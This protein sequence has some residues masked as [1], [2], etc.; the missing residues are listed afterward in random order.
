MTAS[1]QGGSQEMIEEVRGL[2]SQ[3]LQDIRKLF[4]N[5][6]YFACKGILGYD[7]LREGAH[8]PLCD[9]LTYDQ[10]VRK[11]VLMPRGH[12]KSTI[13][14]IGRPIQLAARNP[15]LYRGCIQNE[16]ATKANLFIWEIKQHWEK[17]QVLRELYPELVPEK[18]SGPGSDWSADM[19]SIRRTAVMKESTWTAIGAGGS[20]VGLHFNHIVPDDLIGEQHKASRADMERVKVWN[21]GQ[22]ALLDNA[23]TDE[24]CWIGTRKAVDDVYADT[25][26]VFEGELALFIREPI[27]DG[28]PIFPLK[29]SME[30]FQRM[31][32]KTPEEWA[33]DYMNNPIG[34]GGRDWAGLAI[35]EWRLADDGMTYIYRDPDTDERKTC[36]RSMLDIVITVDPNSGKPH[37]PDQAAVVVHGTTPDDENLILETKLGRPSP[38][39][40]V[41]WTFDSAVHWKPRVVGIE[42]AGQQNTLFYFHKKCRKKGI[43]FNAVDLHHKNQD[44]ERRI[45]TALDTP[46]K[47]RRIFVGPQMLTLK[48]AIKFFPQLSVHMWDEIDALSY[49]PELYR[50]GL[51]LEDLTRKKAN[52]ERILA[53]RGRTG[54]GRSFR[55]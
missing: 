28:A 14:T 46:L 1:W 33:H 54:Y 20:A 3:D 29:F 35:P 41:D 49:G 37:A 55:R 21:H 25:M 7:Q 48:T 10:S 6:L 40:L 31:M 2:S 24:I 36:H 42:E 32:E 4:E 16:N 22:E 19:A 27:E 52:E 53:L 45:R 39:G 23:D 47:G 51:R 5:D 38:D 44:K 34:K 26:E 18:F 12:L 13:G 43:F 17:N 11:M 15:N 9:F 8:R 30:R 50:K